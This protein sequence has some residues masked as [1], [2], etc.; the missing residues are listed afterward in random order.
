MAL[1]FARNS[2]ETQ[3][4][5]QTCGIYAD[6]SL[7]AKVYQDVE[8]TL[9]DFE[10]GILGEA[11]TEGKY[12]GEG[13]RGRGSCFHCMTLPQIAWLPVHIVV[14]SMEPVAYIGCLA[15]LCSC[16]VEEKAVGTLVVREGV[17]GLAP[18][19]RCMCVLPRQREPGSEARNKVCG[20][21]RERKG[22]GRSQVGAGEQ[23]VCT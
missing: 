18:R 10:V 3:Y 16:R 14:R 13:T 21:K 20:K 7:G 1:T 4:D 8:D 2:T 9:K 19:V 22:E 12:Q 11:G 5:V 6:F 17:S 15:Q 23:V